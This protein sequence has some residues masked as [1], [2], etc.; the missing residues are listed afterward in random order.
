MQ[1]REGAGAGEGASPAAAPPRDPEPGF[2]V[3]W[4]PRAA[5]QAAFLED[6]G[7]PLR[8]PVERALALGPQPHPYRRIRRDGDA[9]RLA[10]K[11]WRVRFHADGRRIEV[12]SIGTGYRERDLW[13]GEDPEILPHRAF[14]ARF[15]RA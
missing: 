4:T 1:H 8:E 12:L 15:G 14:V 7:V 10:V 2:Q 6:A 13:T 5:E 3:V 11:S 9:M